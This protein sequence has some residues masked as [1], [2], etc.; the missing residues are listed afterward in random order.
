MSIKLFDKIN[1]AVAEMSTGDRIRF[2]GDLC[3]LAPRSRKLKKHLIFFANLELV[4]DVKFVNLST[5]FC[6][7][8]C[9]LAMTAY[10]NT[11]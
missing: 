10:F 8:V 11:V 5:Y 9:W 7:T 1:S 2:K 4:V 3:S 6:T